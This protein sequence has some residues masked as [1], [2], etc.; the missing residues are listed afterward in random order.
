M[1][2]EWLFDL[3]YRKY[4]GA[5]QAESALIDVCSAASSTAMWEREAG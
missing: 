4:W 2:W 5:L 1:V 3:M